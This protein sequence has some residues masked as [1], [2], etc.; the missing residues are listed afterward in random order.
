[1]AEFKPKKQSSRQ[2]FQFR[3]RSKT[4]QLTI[5]HM[6]CIGNTILKRI[7]I[8]EGGVATDYAP[9]QV[10]EGGDP[11]GLFKTLHGINIKLD[12]PQSEFWSNIKATHRD[13]L[14]QYHNGEL[15]SSLGI[16]PDVFSTQLESKVNN[17]FSSFEQRLEGVKTTIQDSTSRYTD[18]QLANARRTLIERIDSV[19]S[20]VDGVNTE[21]SRQY[22]E[23]IQRIN[24]F[25]TTVANEAERYTDTQLA[26]LRETLIETVDGKV[27]TVRQ[28]IGGFERRLNDSQDQLTQVLETVNGIQTTVSGTGGLST[29]VTQLK[30]LIDS[31][32]SSSD[33]STLI[34]QNPY[35]IWL[36]VQEKVQSEANKAKMNGREIVSALELAPSGVRISGKNVRIDGNTYIESGTIK[37]GHIQELSADKITAGVLNAARVRV[38]NLDAN[39]LTG[40][41]T[42]F[43]QSYWNKINNDVEI[44]AEGIQMRGESIWR[45]ANYDSTGIVL[46]RYD[47]NLQKAVKQGVVGYFKGASYESRSHEYYMKGRSGNHSVGIGGYDDIVFGCTNNRNDNG[48]DVKMIMSADLDGIQTKRISGIS[49]ETGFGITAFNARGEH[50]SVLNGTRNSRNMLTFGDTLVTLESQSKIDFYVGSGSKLMELS[51]ARVKI[52]GSMTHTSDQRLK[53]NIKEASQNS[54]DTILNIKYSDFD[55]KDGRQNQFGFIAQQVQSLDNRLIVSDGEYLNYDN[56]H[57][58]HVVGH[59]LQQS[60]T[61]LSERLETLERENKALKQ[62]LERLIA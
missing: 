43:V 52:N 54:L 38:I 27:S 1:M 62:Q 51:Y 30:S 3:P 55:W 6:G 36:A 44:T 13:F 14:I 34:R 17:R 22:S 49:T 24:G 50:A 35:S 39:Q 56:T 28:T 47:K 23:L 48:F 31:K 10:V 2:S 61:A 60:H 9:T 45:Y 15:K 19:D 53:T 58:V 20:K 4:E 21:T 25:K 46:M 5:Q 16:S 40:N 32:V 41:L 8:E 42:N 33:F 59:A 57:Y 11:T 26:N 12:N 29:Q 18:T 7:Q 37:S